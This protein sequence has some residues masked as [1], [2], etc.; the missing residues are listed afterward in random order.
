MYWSKPLEN[1]PSLPE[2]GEA[3][4]IPEQRPDAPSHTFGGV[5]FDP[6]IPGAL[7]VC[8]HDGNYAIGSPGIEPPI[9]DPGGPTCV[10]DQ[11]GGPRRG[12]APD[13]A[14]SAAAGRGDAQIVVV[15][16]I[17]DVNLL[18]DLEAR[19]FQIQIVP[20]AKSAS[21]RGVRSSL[22]KIVLPTPLLAQLASRLG[23]RGSDKVPCRCYFWG[24]CDYCDCYFIIFNNFLF[25]L[26]YSRVIVTD[27][28]YSYR[29]GISTSVRR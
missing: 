21:W 27:G 25:F 17:D 1:D 18:K 4:A 15:V 19:D 26:R 28:W 24:C 29:H 6:G 7:A 22:A 9:Y 16:E 20:M 13:L 2:I 3:P 12:V 10:V 14:Q 11:I 5:A 8:D 23:H